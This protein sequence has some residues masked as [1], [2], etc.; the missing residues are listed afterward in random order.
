MGN[1]LVEF[2]ATPDEQRVW[3]TRVLSRHDTWCARWQPGIGEPEFPFGAALLENSI[4]RGNDEAMLFLGR[5]DLTALPTWRENERGHRDIDFVRSQA[6]QVV[7]SRVV[8]DVLLEGRIAIMRATYYEDAGISVRPVRKWFHEVGRSLEQLRLPG[9]MLL[10]RTTTGRIKEW[11]SVIIS[12]GAAD[13]RQSGGSLKQFVDGG[14]EFDVRIE[15]R[16]AK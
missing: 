12:R 5:K 2:Y 1:L 11:Q 13:W 16:R 8:R 6:I 4:F 7:P 3:L 9:A 14:V 15:N 10:Q